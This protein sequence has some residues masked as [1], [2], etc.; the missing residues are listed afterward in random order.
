MSQFDHPNFLVIRERCLSGTIST[1]AATSTYIGSTLKIR[2]KCVV[3]GATCRVGSGGSA[4]G[5]QTLAIVKLDSLGTI[6]STKQVHSLTSSAGASALNDVYDISL[7]SPF[8]LASIG[9]MAGITG[10]AASLDKIVVLSDVIW[11]Y[12]VLPFVLPKTAN[13]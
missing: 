1:A 6:L 9:E 8:T 11:R 13:M 4:A 2:D 3:L 7:A 5:T 12:R 10:N